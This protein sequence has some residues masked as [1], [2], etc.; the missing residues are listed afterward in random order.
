MSAATL[1]ENWRTTEFVFENSDPGSAVAFLNPF[2]GFSSEQQAAVEEFEQYLSDVA[3]YYHSMGFKAPRLPL[4]DG[5]KGGK[6]FRVNLF[7]YD[8]GL[9]I[10]RAGPREDGTTS[11]RADLSRAITNGKPTPRL[12]EDLAHELFHNIQHAYISYDALDD[13]NWIVEGQAQAVG[14][15]AAR[16]RGIDMYR[17]KEDGYRL[18]GRPYY[19]PLWVTDD[20]KAEDYRTASF[21]RY[22]GEHYAAAKRNGRAGIT[23][24][25]PDYSYLVQILNQPLARRASAAADAQWLDAGLRQVSGL[26]LQR[27]HAA[28][29]ST[30]AAYVPDRLT[31]AIRGTAEEAQDNWLQYI[32]GGCNALALSPR[33]PSAS[34]LLP[35]RENAARCFKVN[36]AGTGRA[37]VSIQTRADTVAALQALQIGLAGGER[38]GGAQV[39]PS[40]AGGGYIAH[41]R[42]RINAGASYVFIVSN[43]AADPAS[44]LSQ[45]LTMNATYSQWV[46]DLSQPRSQAAARN[47]AGT[48]SGAA[49]K[50]AAAASASEDAPATDATRQMAQDDLATGLTAL[51]NQ[52]ALGA[53]ATFERERARCVQPFGAVSCGP[54][55]S[56]Q[57]ALTPGSLGD[58]TQTT[59]TGGALAQFM[60]QITA[61]ADHGALLTDAQWQTAMKKVRD[62]EGSTVTITIPL[63]EYGFTGAFDNAEIVVNGGAGHGNFQA[64]GPEDSIPGRGQE[65]RQSGRVSILEFSPYVLRGR[66]E[67]DLTELSAV[68]FISAGEDMPLPIVR[69]ISG[70]FVIAAPWEGDRDV[71][72]YQPQST[73]SALQDLSQAFPVVGNMNL[74]DILPPEVLEGQSSATAGNLPA[75]P[76]SDFPS[77]ACDCQPVVS[78]T[79]ECKPICK[80]KLRACWA[81]DSRRKKLAEQQKPQPAAAAIRQSRAEYIEGLRREGMDEAQIERLM[82]GIDAFWAEN[83]G[84]PE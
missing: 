6:A 30:L 10:A 3:I 22:V 32:Y 23:P 2:S 28:F 1:A 16:R 45:N 40:P 66:F 64:L 54:I 51:S 5:R 72:V 82:P 43:M 34:T 15:E 48:Q 76:V 37:D 4:V 29:V 27:F 24:I 71:A 56:I 65:Y 63:I 35:L 25:T 78:L 11:L 47:P 20:S 59:G 62:T 61:I 84:W 19:Q 8:D 33:A 9:P 36:V 60:A 57:L 80:V 18:G 49:A 7:D 42:F 26:G 21:W 79:P 39:V 31:K 53:H 58:M 52:T 38:I 70:E 14:M 50:P 12:F 41:W 44:T 17:G 73:E 75:S 83:G 55:T 81:E 67:A 77:C 46:S 69:Q 68:D 13:R 74:A